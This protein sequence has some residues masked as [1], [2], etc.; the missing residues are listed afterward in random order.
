MNYKPF[1]GYWFYGGANANQRAAFYCSWG[2]MSV[3]ALVGG[4]SKAIFSIYYKFR[5]Q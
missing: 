4:V 2:L 3:A 5:R 1:C